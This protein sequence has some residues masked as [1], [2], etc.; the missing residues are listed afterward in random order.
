M[1]KQKKYFLNANTAVLHIIDGCHHAKYIPK[2][3]KCYITED[4]AIKDNQKYM[5]YCRLCFKNK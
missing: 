1:T 4:D 2:D 5:K 3:S